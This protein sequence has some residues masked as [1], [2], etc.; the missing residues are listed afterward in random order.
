MINCCNR[1]VIWPCIPIRFN[2]INLLINDMPFKTVK[3]RPVKNPTAI[4]ADAVTFEGK[5][6]VTDKGDRMYNYLLSSEWITN[7]LI[8]K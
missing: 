5:G 4:A 2:E 6:L 3:H 7:D 8:V 1:A